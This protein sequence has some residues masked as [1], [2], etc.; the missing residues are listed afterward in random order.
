[1]S[2]QCHNPVIIN[3]FSFYLKENQQLLQ[4]LQVLYCWRF[5]L[6]LLKDCRFLKRASML[7]LKYETTGLASGSVSPLHAVVFY[8]FHGARTI[9]SDF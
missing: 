7:S 1:M 9:E 8:S 4:K 2:S 3:I 6:L 5:Y